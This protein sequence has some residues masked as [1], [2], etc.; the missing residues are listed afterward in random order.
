[1]FEVNIRY[2][3]RAKTTKEKKNYNDRN[4]IVF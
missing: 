2:G 4:R 1:M 3:L